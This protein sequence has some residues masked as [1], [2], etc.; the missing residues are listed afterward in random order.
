M[1]PYYNLKIKNAMVKS[2]FFV[3]KYTNYSHFQL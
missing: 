3:S 1:K 2:G